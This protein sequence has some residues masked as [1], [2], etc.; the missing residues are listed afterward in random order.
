MVKVQGIQMKTQEQLLL[1]KEDHNLKLQTENK[2]LI[3]KLGSVNQE[4]EEKIKEIQQAHNDDLQAHLRRQINE[5]EREAKNQQD[6]WCIKERQYKSKLSALSTELQTI[7]SEMSN[8]QQIVHF[9]ELRCLELE[10]QIKMQET[11]IK[12]LHLENEKEMNDMCELKER[13]LQEIESLS[14]KN[15]QTPDQFKFGFWTKDEPQLIDDGSDQSDLANML[16]RKVAD[17]RSKL[18][19]LTIAYNDLKHVSQQEI[20]KLKSQVEVEKQRRL[21][22]QEDKIEKSSALMQELY[23]RDKRIV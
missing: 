20:S 2:A 18:G 17:L 1:N 8:Q 10:K 9:R 16:R 15:R 11:Q 14:K 4:I 12:N 13:L 3:N 23:V 6:D 19:R 21:T 22:I 5:W 7:Q